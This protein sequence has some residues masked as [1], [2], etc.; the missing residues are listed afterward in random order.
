VHLESK[1]D[2][3]VSGIIKLPEALRQASV[4]LS[5][6][7]PIDL[8]QPLPLHTKV[9]LLSNVINIDGEIL[10]GESLKLKADAVIPP[11]TL[12]KG[13]DPD[14]KFSALSPMQI[15]AEQAG[16]KLHATL[17][18]QKLKLKAAYALESG[19]A[20]GDI[21]LA[22]THL[23]VEGTVPKEIVVK[24]NSR[25]IQSLRKAVDSIYPVELPDLHGNITLETKINDLR[26]AT[27]TLHSKEI[28]I[29]RDAK[30]GTKLS[31]LSL[32]AKADS[33]KVILERY[34]LET[35]GIKLFATKP[36]A[37]RFKGGSIV[38]DPLWVN[39]ALKSTGSYDLTH[40]KGTL[41]AQASSLKISHTLADITTALGIKTRINGEKIAVEGKVHL[42]GGKIKYDLNQ[43]HFAADS[44]IVILQKQ[45][46]KS[47]GF[48]EKNVQIHV[49]LDSSKPLRYKMKNIDI[50]LMPDLIV[51]K[52]YGGTVKV[53]GKVTLS[54]GGYYLFEG[55]RFVLQKS[56]IYFKGKPT[57]PILNINIVYKHAGTTVHV[58]VSGTA[59]EPSLYFSSDPHMSREEI[60]SFILFDTGSGGGE[61]KAGDVTNLVAGTLVKSLFA[62]MG[63]KLDHLVLTG[64]GFEVGKKISDRITIIYDQEE[65]SSVKIRVEN[66][67]NIETDISFGTNSRSADIFYKREF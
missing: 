22:G 60:L 9:K 46:K 54:P 2:I 13:F 30:T 62:N 15:T 52:R 45:R 41:N 47:N 49:T 57:A 59:A 36:S 33:S 24:L 29:G 12:L 8:H 5:A 39:D 50:S 43:K 20:K 56:S 16:E 17:H 55:K 35:E 1:R 38:V 31:N 61:N 23:A 64:A 34:T 65:K 44:D 32:R 28:M 19:Q 53:N 63:L 26:S 18:T 7:L 51:K 3:A 21:D 40:K 10:Y 67:K 27:V 4:S 14:I 66:S 37:I 6:D 48:V 25:S 11:K 42:K 58:K